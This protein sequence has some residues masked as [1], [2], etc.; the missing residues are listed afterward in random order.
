MNR[1]ISSDFDPFRVI[2]SFASE[3]NCADL[4]IETFMGIGLPFD[5]IATGK[6]DYSHAL[7]IRA[8][9]ARVLAVYD[10]LSAEARLAAA[11]AAVGRFFSRSLQSR[12]ELLATLRKIGWGLQDDRLVALD[13]QVREMFFPRDSQ[14]DAFVAIREVI[15]KAQSELMLVDPYCDRT[16]FG[17]LESSGGR[18]MNIRLLCRNKSGGLKAE[19]QAF[20]AQYPQVSI[21][22]RKS[23]DFHD[24]FLV[25]DQSICVHLGASINHAGSRAFMI[26]AV[27]DASNRDALIKSVN[28]AWSAGVSV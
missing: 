25:V 14:W 9:R 22:L 26:S 24:R 7:R 3:T 13:A 19:A 23:S 12:G 4:F 10:G 5:V 15:D 28:T 1:H 18:P 20:G 6:D 21:E 17:I 16:F 2:V 11:N 8:F 27:E